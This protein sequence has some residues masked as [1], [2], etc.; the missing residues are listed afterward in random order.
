[1]KAVCKP[2]EF[3]QLLYSS[4]AQAATFET[5]TRHDKGTSLTMGVASPVYTTVMGWH[6]LAAGRVRNR[7]KCM[8]EKCVM[9]I[10]IVHFSSHTLLLP[11]IL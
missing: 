2:R 9:K 11:K 5:T 3:L 10:Y 4:A 8:I 6:P 1:M 7:G